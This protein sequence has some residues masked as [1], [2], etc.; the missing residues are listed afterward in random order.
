MLCR[1]L[2]AK[3]Q[4]VWGAD[5][6]LVKKHEKGVLKRNRPVRGRVK[7]PRDRD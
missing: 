4:E 3:G 1:S 5:D 6:E 7:L 2:S